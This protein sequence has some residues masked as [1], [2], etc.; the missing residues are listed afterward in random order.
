[1]EIHPLIA[2][3]DPH[4]PTVLL[5]EDIEVHGGRGA[6]PDCLYYRPSARLVRQTKSEIAIAAF[7]YQYSNRDFDF[8]DPGP[9]CTYATPEYRCTECVIAANHVTTLHLAAP[10]IGPRLVDARDG[11]T[12]G[13]VWPGYQFSVGFLPSGLHQTS[14]RRM[15]PSRGRFQAS[16]VYGS[17][18][19]H[20]D[21]SGDLVSKINVEIYV[22][23]RSPL[24]SGKDHLAINGRRGV[25]LADRGGRGLM[26]QTGAGLTAIIYSRSAV[27]G[28]HPHQLSRATLLHMARSLHL[29][30]RA[31]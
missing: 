30:R 8:L 16:R 24:R 15:Q 18:G 27:I 23:P 19:G 28:S 17:R 20:F 4:R 2:Y 14:A 3:P 11:S 29:P 13:L 12:V 21:P 26:W 7:E 6:D 31:R 10:L 5:V 1:H 9:G 22:V 25:W